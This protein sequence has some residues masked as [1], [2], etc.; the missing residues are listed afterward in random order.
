[1]FVGDPQLFGDELLGGEDLEVYVDVYRR[2]GFTGG[3][4]G[5]RALHEDWREGLGH[6]FVIDK[7]GLMISAADDFFLPPDF[8]GGLIL[9]DAV[10]PRT[11]GWTRSGQAESGDARL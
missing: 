5:Y 10:A 2:T 3:L 9:S 8:T 11:E 7:S 1:V 6:E 4:N